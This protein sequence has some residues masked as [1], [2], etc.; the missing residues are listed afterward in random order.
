MNDYNPYNETEAEIDLIG[1]CLSVCKQWRKLLIFFL[2]GALIGCGVSYF[3]MNQLKPENIEGYL[4][5]LEAEELDENAIRQ[6][7]DFQALYEASLERSDSSVILNMDQNN[8]WSAQI[9]Y[10]L[11]SD[12]DSIDAV[13]AY[14]NALLLQGSNLD[15][16]LA[17]SELN[18]STNEIKELV[19]ISCGKVGLDNQ[20][21]GDAN[22]LDVRSANL[23]V[24]LSAPTED[25]L[26]RMLAQT[27]EMIDDSIRTLA[28]QYPE[29]QNVE[30]SNSS[31]FGYSASVASQQ[32][33]YLA[34]RQSILKNI[35][36]AEKN[37]SDDELLYYGYY[38]D[39]D[40]LDEYEYGF[41]KKW[42]VIAAVA[43]AFIAACWYAVKYIFDKHIKSEDE[44][45]SQFGIQVLGSIDAKEA[46]KNVIDKWLAG[47]DNAGKLAANSPEYLSSVIGGIEAESIALLAGGSDPDAKAL[48][49]KLAASDDRLCNAGDLLADDTAAEAL[50]RC[51]G[52]IVLAHIDQTTRPELTRI[53]ELVR[54]F[55]KETYGAVVIR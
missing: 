51:G 55:G 50:K 33:D 53:L 52:A 5:S 4:A 39:E 31:A 47:L 21:L 14:Y 23:T 1:L 2:I 26:N 34:D 11:T 32:A 42:P 29:F 16:L 30:L 35:T 44:L 46:P 15:D 48:A 45:S 19:S 8:V 22:A 43:L 28:S 7:A 10:F 27:E 41:S 40:F 9:R 24:N 12:Y 36:D 49:E 54:K 38:F 3:K 17:A 18:C 6:Y 20:I 37:L 13:V 25:C